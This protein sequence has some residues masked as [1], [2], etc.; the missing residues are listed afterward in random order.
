M[1]KKA[2]TQKPPR[3][4]LAA[5]RI[6][7]GATQPDM[8]RDTGISISH[9]QRMEDGDYQRLP[10]QQLL[11]C[12]IVLEVDLDELIEDEY[13]GWTVFSPDARKPPTVPRWKAR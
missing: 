1:P 10:Y 3:T 13:K 12:A 2:T 6:K 4:K 11:N 7:R 8:V 9:Y 5:W